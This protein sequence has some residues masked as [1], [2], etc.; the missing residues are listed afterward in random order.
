MQVRVKS[1][2][3]EVSEEVS[4][5]LCSRTQRRHITYPQ[6]VIASNV[7]LDD[8]LYS[9]EGFGWRRHDVDVAIESPRDADA[10]RDSHYASSD[11]EDKEDRS[12]RTQMTTRESMASTTA[13][14]AVLR[15][16]ERRTI[17]Q[18]SGSSSNTSFALASSLLEM[19]GPGTPVTL[20]VKLGQNVK[21]NCSSEQPLILHITD[22]RTTVMLRNLPNNYTRVHFLKLLD[23][24]G[25]ASRYN[26]AYFPVDFETER[27]LGFAFVNLT[28]N[29]A[30]QEMFS[31]FNGFCRWGV[32][33]MK[34]CSVNWS[35]ADQQGILANI[36]RYRNSS[37]MHSCVPDEHKPILLRDG[38]PV[39]FPKPTKRL[40]PPHADFGCRARK[41]PE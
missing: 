15:R 3:L 2:F 17:T 37:V 23:S 1:T 32:S 38:K 21:S 8:V 29:S 41:G 35:S 36:R 40:W 14:S 13:S 10:D 18:A 20:G 31:H 16:Q 19:R 28:S 22:D 6:V 39:D 7:D 27:G 30:A 4:E 26:F 25:F 11:G 12:T 33:S 5:P 34:V 24:Q 9:H